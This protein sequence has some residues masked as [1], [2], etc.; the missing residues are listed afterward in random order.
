M[1]VQEL[2][3]KLSK[4][5]RDMEISRVNSVFENMDGKLTL[6]HMELSKRRREKGYEK[7]Q[8]EMD[9]RGEITSFANRW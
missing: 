4:Y 8:E 6:T 3:I 2:I 5:P 9:R 1:T 7:H